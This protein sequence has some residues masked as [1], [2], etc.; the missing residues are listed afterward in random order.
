L[1]AALTA[2]YPLSDDPTTT[3]HVRHHPHATRLAT[4]LDNLDDLTGTAGEQD[5]AT[6][7]AIEDTAERDDAYARLK[8]FM[9]ELKGTA[10]GVLRNKPGLFA[11][12]EL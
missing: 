8:D 12:L 4:L 3:S 11:K 9:K 7:D 1:A 6:G 5:T 2:A 10:R